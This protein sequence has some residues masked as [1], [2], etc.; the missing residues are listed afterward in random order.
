MSD[1]IASKPSE[2]RL[3]TPADQFWKVLNVPAIWTTGWL[4]ICCCTFMN[5]ADFKVD[6]SQINVDLQVVIKLGLV[7][8]GGLYGLHGLISNRRVQQVMGSFP[9]LWIVVISFFYFVAVLG[10]HSPAHSLV[11]ALSI[12]CILLMTVTAL[13][14]MGV[15]NVISAMLCGM[16]LFV[17]LSW[18]AYF[19]VPELGV[20][21][22]KL[23]EGKIAHR[24][25]GLA[26]ANTLGQ[27]S[28]ITVVL[29]VVLI[30]TYRVRS[31][32]VLVVGLLA[33]GALVNSLSRT[34]MM[35]TMIA[36]VIGYRHI[37]IRRE[38]IK[39]YIV[40]GAVA[41]LMVLIASTQF[42]VN[43]KL[44][45]KLSFLSK[46][47]D[48]EELTTATGRS[49]IWNYSLILLQK[50]PL[51]GYGAATQKHFLA[52]YSYYTH[53]L[54]LNVAFSSGIFGG[55]ACLCMVF[56]RIK[57]MFRN[58]HPLA[59]AVI[60]FILVNGIFEN[61]IFSVVAGMPTMIWIIA[62]C[63]PLL[64]DDP[65]VSSGQRNLPDDK[66]GTDERFLRLGVS[67]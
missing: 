33:L 60:V 59:D 17:C 19:A 64:T 42:D 9:V 39:F 12:Q 4:L 50:K 24:M 28:G 65:V 62:L 34:S 61:V 15:K 13:V 8:C 58:R 27:Y 2:F 30:A 53:N 21:Q 66:S 45:S 63:W 5:L 25:S 36:L 32:F 37:F 31:L 20:L 47:G 43:K 6:K 38:H 67:G 41:L 22:E 10:S 18:L 14:H 51:T 49:E 56:G 44:V 11:S 23:P 16:S 3:N 1:T 55:I 46:S 57:A 52:D 35:A 7:V 26:H 54:V 40:G 48:T 29:I